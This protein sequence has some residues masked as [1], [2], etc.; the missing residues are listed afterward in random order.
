MA[1]GDFRARMKEDLDACIL[2]S[3]V[4]GILHCAMLSAFKAFAA[5]EYNDEMLLFFLAVIL[6][7]R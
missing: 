3:P 5:S 7:S 1:S 6:A 2:P 4:T